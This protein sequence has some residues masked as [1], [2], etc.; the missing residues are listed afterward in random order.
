[1]DPLAQA[2]GPETG[3]NGNV[4]EAVDPIKDFLRLRDELIEGEWSTRV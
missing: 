3:E 4:A 1:L 2:Q